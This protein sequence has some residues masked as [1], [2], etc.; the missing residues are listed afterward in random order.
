VSSWRRPLSVNVIAVLPWLVMRV[1]VR[2]RPRG[3]P[4]Y[5]AGDRSR[6]AAE[7]AVGECSL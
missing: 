3:V 1:N 2:H 7:D 5:A 6:S 4:C